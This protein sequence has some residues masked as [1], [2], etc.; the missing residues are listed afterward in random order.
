MGDSFG[1][2]SSRWYRIS[3][4]I[5]RL[6]R[7]CCLGLRL[8]DVCKLTRIADLI[9][10]C[11]PIVVV[12]G[13]SSMYVGEAQV[14]ELRYQLIRRLTLLRPEH[15]IGD[16]NARVP[17]IRGF[18]LRMPAVCSMCCAITDGALSVPMLQ[19]Y[20][21]FS[22]TGNQ[23]EARRHHVRTVFTAAVLPPAGCE[24]ASRSS[25]RALAG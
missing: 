21:E 17:L 20:V 15:D 22:P 5:S 25:D 14:G 12:V 23:I 3:I 24:T 10:D 6:R 16:G 2:L 18:P 13:Q 19:L 11:V 9:I 1:T 4:G 8:Q 7:A